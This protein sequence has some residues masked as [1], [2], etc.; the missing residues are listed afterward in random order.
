M[1]MYLAPYTDQVDGAF[2]G[3][4]ILEKKPLGFPQEGGGIPYISSLFYWACAWSDEGGLIAEHPHQAFEILSFVLDGEIEHYDNKA[5]AWKK[6][7]AGDV[8]II[9]AGSG[10]THAERMHAGS[11]MFQIWFD[12]HLD[13]AV[14]QPPSY[15]DYRAES[16]PVTQEGDVAKTTLIGPGSPFEMQS[17]VQAFRNVY[18]PGSVELSLPPEEVAVLYCLDGTFSFSDVRKPDGSPVQLGPGDTFCW[19]PESEE[20]TRLL[21]DASG[22]K[23]ELFILQMPARTDYPLY[24]ERFQYAQS[25]KTS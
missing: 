9:R 17:P 15:D 2:D 11:R 10:I 21:L 18:K 13:R 3:G 8:Q 16:F 20:Q 22:D 12:P 4:K 23:P 6:L 14:Q 7:K 25:A 1:A 24:T 19:I 5:A